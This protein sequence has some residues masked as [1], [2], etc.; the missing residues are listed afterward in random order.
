MKDLVGMQVYGLT[1]KQYIG[2]NFWECLC[3]CGETTK[4]E[5]WQLTGKYKKRSCG[6]GVRGKNNYLWKGHEKITGHYWSHIRKD[7][8]KRHLEFSMTIEE[9]WNKF[10]KQNERCSLSNTLLYLP[11][12]TTTQESNYTASLDRIDSSQGYTDN[13]TQWVHKDVNMMKHKFT[14]ENFIKWC[15]KIAQYQKGVR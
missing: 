4:A 12:N 6:C 11:T 2:N 13:N 10:V 15:R 7:A 14:Q 5:T 9:A 3:R 8:K 1:V